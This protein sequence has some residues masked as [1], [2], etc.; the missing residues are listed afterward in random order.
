MENKYKKH[1][2]HLQDLPFPLPAP[3]GIDVLLGNELFLPHEKIN[4]NCDLDT[5]TCAKPPYVRG[6]DHSV[7]WTGQ[8]VYDKHKFL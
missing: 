3:G 4:K 6:T 5:R 1:F 7:L 8:G 2:A